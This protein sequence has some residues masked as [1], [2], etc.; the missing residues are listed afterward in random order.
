[1]SRGRPLSPLP[2]AAWIATKLQ[3]LDLETKET[4]QMGARL[5]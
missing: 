4:V 1:M 2:E 5:S 3:R